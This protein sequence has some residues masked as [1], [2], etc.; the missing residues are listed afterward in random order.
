M[1]KNNF[2]A[3]RT[4]TFLA[5]FLFVVLNL[6]PIVP[7]VDDH[8]WPQLLLHISSLFHSSSTPAIVDSALQITNH[9]ASFPSTPSTVDSLF[10]R[11]QHDTITAFD[12]DLVAKFHSAIFVAWNTSQALPME[13][14][15][16][17]PQFSKSIGNSG[18]AIFKNALISGE[19]NVVFDGELIYF[20]GGCEF[21]GRRTTKGNFPIHAVVAANKSYNMDTA[22]WIAQPGTSWYHGF[23]EAFPRIMYVLDFLKSH[24]NA[25]IVA[26]KLLV[27]DR[28]A[29]NVFNPLLGI[30][31]QWIAHEKKKTYKAKRLLVPTATCASVNPDL[32][33]A[34]QHLVAERFFNRTSLRDNGG[35]S[36]LGVIVVQKRGQK[37]G[38]SNH[39]TL[40]QS[41]R[42]QFAGRYTVMEFFGN[43]TLQDSISMHH[44]ATLLVGP[45][46]AGL[47][48][49][50]F[51]KRHVSAML[52]LHPKRG[53]WRGTDAP[54]PCHQRTATSAA[55][56]SRM[57]LME[58]YDNKPLDSF[59]V[60]NITLVLEIAE[61]LLQQISFVSES[62]SPILKEKDEIMGTSSEFRSCQEK[63]DN[64]P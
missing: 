52:E 51:M 23:A 55:V 14:F 18:V 31:N 54:N 16:Y 47:S 7:F 63:R 44:A 10:E 29:A 37:R 19:R 22:V 43:E 59:P 9:S 45:H 3:K 26:H 41:L 53:N 20:A 30:S 32:A 35:S 5:I 36:G 39:D 2:L 17:L 61:S 46:G 13:H 12:E 34:F 15:I 64:N 33:V 25:T 57:I 28:R 4:V 27:Q 62:C 8:S 48:N 21:G 38:I 42:Q 40:V 58:V 50:L 49:V 11:I 1:S 60:E 56:V 24:P 6:F